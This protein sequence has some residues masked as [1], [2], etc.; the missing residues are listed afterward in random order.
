MNI[1]KLK[2]F[3][4]LI[5]ITFFGVFLISIITSLIEFNISPININKNYLFFSGLFLG[6]MGIKIFN[7]LNEV[8]E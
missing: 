2:N 3:M 7:F 1:N 8:F 5:M 6:I 4:I